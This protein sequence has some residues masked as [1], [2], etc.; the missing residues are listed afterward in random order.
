MLQGKYS[1]ANLAYEYIAFKSSDPA[2]ITFARLRRAQALKKMQAYDRGL[3][4]L[5]KINLLSAPDS[6]RPA[7]IYEMVLLS[8]LNKDY[9]ESL[10]RGQ[11]GMSF[12]GNTEQESQ[13]YLLL[14]LAALEEADWKKVSSFG[15]L[16]LSTTLSGNT[17]SNLHEQFDSL[18]NRDLPKIK[19]PAIARKWST[20]IPGSGQ[21]YAGAV[22]D[23]IYNFG[24]HAVVLGIS[25]WT[26]LSGFYVT[27]WLGGATLLQ[28]LHSGG[29]IRA[30][31]ICENKNRLKV[32]EYS[33][34]VK[35]FLISLGKQEK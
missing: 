8:F 18:M 6:I 7:L 29:Q 9:Q 13:V 15:D 34:P 28:K 32:Q 20:I 31:E 24:L 17:E 5:E 11:M 14:S 4:I 30:V 12:I 27:G 19:D 26:F 21:I 33:Q 2:T 23:G 1:E 10:S 3:D 16:Y 22:G 35:E 25:G